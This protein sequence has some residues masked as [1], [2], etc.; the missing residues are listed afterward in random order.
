MQGPVVCVP[1]SIWK[2][3]AKCGRFGI[4]CHVAL[5]FEVTWGE[6]RGERGANLKNARSEIREYAQLLQHLWKLPGGE[7]EDSAGTTKA[8]LR[9]CSGTPQ[10][11]QF[12]P[13][14]FRP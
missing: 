3:T 13:R 9:P 1:R 7:E 14:A 12:Y 11:W 5:L 4:H 2:R 6:M 8:L 10:A